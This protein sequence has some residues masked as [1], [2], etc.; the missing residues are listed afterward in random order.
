MK[1]RSLLLVLSTLVVV[2][3]ILPPIVSAEWRYAIMMA[4][5]TVCHQLPERSFHIAGTSLA[6]CH[7]CTGIYVGIPLAI[8]AGVIANGLVGGKKNWG[9]VLAISLAVMGLD[10]GLTVIEFWE[11]TLLS[12][13]ATGLFFGITAGAYLSIVVAPKSKTGLIENP[14]NNFVL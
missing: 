8:L 3:L 10:W 9:V 1:V 6:V 2:L 5:S 13:V 14:E 11:N 7:R 4:F 12:R